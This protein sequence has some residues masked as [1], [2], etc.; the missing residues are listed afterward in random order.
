MEGF[1]IQGADTVA[2]GSGSGLISGNFIDAQN[3]LCERYDPNFVEDG[4][5]KRPRLLDS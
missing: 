4:I 3:E 1:W 2:G 5:N